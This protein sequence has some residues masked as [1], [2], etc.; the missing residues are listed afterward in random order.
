MGVVPSWV[1]FVPIEESWKSCFLPSLP[2]EDTPG[3]Q[4]SVCKS[5]SRPSPNA[6]T[7]ILDFPAFRTWEV[8]VCC[9]S[10]QSEVMFPSSQSWLR[11]LL[12]HPPPL[13]TP[14]I[15]STARYLRDS[16]CWWNWGDG[17][18]STHLIYISFCKDPCFPLGNSPS[19]ASN[20]MFGGC[21]NARHPSLLF[22][23]A[24][25]LTKFGTAHSPVR[26]HVHA[27]YTL[28]HT[29]IVFFPSIYKT[30]SIFHF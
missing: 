14:I 5:G 28:Q 6:V 25:V 24:H 22:S 29:A 20:S 19:V 3:R 7:L 15:L 30:F 21:W 23:A 8:K 9:L 27:S 13:F 1:A 18:L 10:T 16:L 11:Q 26:P 17:P 2:Y 12:S 4:P